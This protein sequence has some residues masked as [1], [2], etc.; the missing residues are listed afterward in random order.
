M[1]DQ[2]FACLLPTSSC[3]TVNI[4]LFNHL[5][6]LA[7]ITA[8]NMPDSWPVVNT[9]NAQTNA[10]PFPPPGLVP[11]PFL[12][13]GF[14]PPTNLG[15]H[16]SGAP[17]QAPDHTQPFGPQPLAQPESFDPLAAQIRSSLPPSLPMGTQSFLTAEMQE[18]M[19][20]Y[21]AQ[22]QQHAVHQ[23]QQFLQT[24]HLQ[25]QQQQPVVQQPSV[26]PA[27]EPASTVITPKRKKR[28]PRTPIS[29]REPYTTRSK[30][31]APDDGL[32]DPGV[33]PTHTP[34]ARAGPGKALAP[35]PA[36]PA[37]PKT[38]A[39][40]PEP[41]PTVPGQ[42]PAPAPALPALPACPKTAAPVPE[43]AAPAPAKHSLPAPA[44]CKPAAPAPMP[45]P[46]TQSVADREWELLQEE[47]FDLM[48]LCTTAR[49]PSPNAGPTHI[50]DL[51]GSPTL[52]M[53]D[54]QTL[55][56]TLAQPSVRPPSQPAISDAAPGHSLSH[57][58]SG[59]PTPVVDKGKH[60]I[61]VV[62]RPSR[63]DT[64]FINETAS[65]MFDLCKTAASSIG[66]SPSLFVS[67][68]NNIANGNPAVIGSPNSW[69]TFEG[70]WAHDPQRVRAMCPHVTGNSATLYWEEFQKISGYK[71]I[72]AQFSELRGL[73][74]AEVHREKR[75]QF[76]QKAQKLGSQFDALSNAF[77]IHGVFAI[78]GGDVNEDFGL[79]CIHT[80]PG[81]SQFWETRMRCEPDAVIGQLHSHVYDHLSKTYTAQMEPLAP[82]RPDL[83]PYDMITVASHSPPSP[84]SPKPARRRAASKTPILSASTHAKKQSN[85][86]VLSTARANSVKLEA[87]DDGGL[88]RELKGDETSRVR[89]ALHKLFEPM[90]EAVGINIEK[91]IP[92]TH[93]VSQFADQ[94]VIVEDWAPGVP[95]F[96]EVKPGKTKG[97]GIRS[98]GIQHMRDLL[99]ALESDWP[100]RFVKAKSSDIKES[101]ILLFTE[102]APPH[103]F[104]LPQTAACRK[105]FDGEIDFAGPAR[106][107][108]PTRAP[109]M[110][111]SR[112]QV[113]EIEDE[114]SPSPVVSRHQQ[115]RRLETV[116][117]NSDEDDDIPLAPQSKPK[118]KGKAPASTSRKK[119]KT[120]ETIRASHYTAPVL[121]DDNNT[122]DSNFATPS[123]SEVD[124]PRAG[125]KRPSPCDSEP[126]SRQCSPES[127]PSP[128]KYT[129]KAS[130][131]RDKRARS[132]LPVLWSPSKAAASNSETEFPWK[133]SRAR[134]V[135]PVA[136]LPAAPDPT[137][138]LPKFKAGTHFRLSID[139]S[140]RKF[141]VGNT[142]PGATDNLSPLP[143][144]KRACAN[145]EAPA[146]P[147]WLGS[148]AGSSST[149]GNTPPLSSSPPAQPQLQPPSSSSILPGPPSV[150]S[151][152][153]PPALSMHD[154]QNV[155]SHFKQYAEWCCSNNLP[156]P[157]FPF[158]G[159]SHQEPS[160]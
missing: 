97:L 101:I 148:L 155:S 137:L 25:A 17:M 61:R 36:R 72:L 78:V 22:L 125:R 23:H 75:K 153:L 114:G 79:A 131:A 2:H 127:D 1:A 119:S 118:D 12:F 85:S 145:K 24:Q 69:N 6:Q 120:V 86:R 14:V 67:A 32:S 76:A 117:S 51:F 39:L 136:G 81:A 71:E 8:P 68:F 46:V 28:S 50:N 124:T 132:A 41:A 143:R 92:W 27:E 18:Q 111:A 100:P 122:D 57:L 45:V 34:A 151:N 157:P 77:D 84:P 26:S 102:A 116:I 105:Y 87:S 140:M 129:H 19:A 60:P 138:A 94:G 159:A 13:P 47:G 37:P 56:P 58:P 126:A 70:L 53:F 135:S 106:L 7:M 149:H 48:D 95:F 89:S 112:R 99:A 141:M 30:T 59:E 43:P 107:R 88:P 4:K 110:P 128:I 20:T 5:N 9:E 40:A 96:G 74:Q 65:H 123:E 54:M 66:R 63:G 104:I 35:A 52:R 160:V 80:T 103:S 42:A 146:F 158:G 83:P 33:T 15:M 21:W 73:Q 3:P 154:L 62:G 134:P 38:A 144:T 139:P 49:T 31:S 64:E 93:A 108:P 115:K 90:F 44:P 133:K 82:A 109:P 91:G 55:K 16:P 29:S 121:F 10:P 142:I 11:P 113:I 130:S 147:S 98:I 150:D 152:P 156:V